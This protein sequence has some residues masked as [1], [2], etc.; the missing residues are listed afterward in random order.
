LVGWALAEPL[1]TPNS[2]EPVYAVYMGE[3][4]YFLV[5]SVAVGALLGACLA[6]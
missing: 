1:V 3:A 5:L 2:P 4:K 6:F